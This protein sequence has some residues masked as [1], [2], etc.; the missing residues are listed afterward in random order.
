MI[1]IKDLLN[2]TDNV[3]QQTY[4]EENGIPQ[5][6][7][8][9]A[10][11]FVEK[12][13]KPILEL[14]NESVKAVKKIV[15]GSQTYVP[16]DGTI[17]LPSEEASV[18]IVAL[19]STTSYVETGGK[20]A[21]HVRI[22]STEGGADTGSI[23]EVE[24]Q[25]FAN[26]NY[27]TILTLSLPSMPM[28][29]TAFEEIDITDVI[30]DGSSQIR[31]VAKDETT[32]AV[33]R[34]IFQSVVKAT[35]GVT[36]VFAW[37]RAITDLDDG[38]PV[39]YAISGT[40]VQKTMHL[41]IYSND[42]KQYRDFEYIIGTSTYT[43]ANPWTPTVNPNDALTDIVKI[44]SHGV[45]TIEAWVTCTSDDNTYS[46]DHVRNQVM[47]VADPSSRNAYLM[48]QQ[49]NTEVNNYVQEDPLFQFAVYNPLNPEEG[50]KVSFLITD[51]NQEQSYMNTESMAKNGTK[52]SVPGTIEI[53]GASL[54][55]SSYAYFRAKDADGFN[56]LNGTDSIIITVDNNY[57]FS[58]VSGADLYINPSNR[59][60]GEANPAQILNAAKKNN[61]VGATFEGFSFDNNDGWIQAAD[62]RRVLRILAGQHV[63]IDYDPFAEF[64]TNYAANVTIELDVKI[65]N[66]TNETD[67]II[68]IANFVLASGK[69]TGAR[70]Y[71]IEGLVMTSSKTTE[72]E[73][74]FGFRE[75]VRTHI[76]IN[77]CSAIYADPDSRNTVP[78]VR[79]FVNANPYREFMFALKQNE[80]GRDPY[81]I[82]IG[83]SGADIDIYSIKVYRKALSSQN[84]MQNYKSSLPTSAQ[85]LTFAD[86]NDIIG[87]DGTIS[88][89]LAREKY[90]CIVHHGVPTSI[91][92]PDATTCWLHIDHIVNGVYDKD[93]SGDICRETASLPVKGQGSTAKHYCDW[94]Q[95]YD[96]KK[97]KGKITVDGAEVID[98]WI[99]GNG[100]YKGAYY[101][102]NTKDAK[103]NKLVGKIN[104][105]SSMQSHKMGATNAYNDLYHAVMG[106]S[107][108]TIMAEDSKARCTC[109]ED[110][111]FFFV[112]ETETSTPRFEGI[113]TFGSGK[114]DKKT[115]GYD[116]EVY[117]DFAMFEGSDNDQPVT[118]FERPWNDDVTYNPAEEYYEYNGKGNIDF[119]AGAVYEDEDE[120]EIPTGIA[121]DV[122]KNFINFG[123]LHCTDLQ[124]WTNNGGTATSLINAAD[125]ADIHS[126]Y[127]ITSPDDIAEIGDLFSWSPL[128]AAW[129]RA[130]INREN[131]NIFDENPSVEFSADYAATN[132]SLIESIITRF[133]AS[134]KNY[135]NVRSKLFHSC[136][137]ENLLAGSDNCAKNT[138]YV[139]DP[140]KH[141]INFHADDL[142]TIFKTD[143]VGWQTK[144]YYVDRVHHIDD[145]GVE[146]YSG[147][148][149][150]FFNTFDRAYENEKQQMMNDI[151]TAMA[152]IGGSVNGFM[153]KYFFGIQRAIPCIAY[154]EQARIRYEKRQIQVNENIITLD[155][156]DPITQQLGSQLE[157]EL[158]Y[159]DRRLVYFMSYAAYGSF[160]VGGGSGVSGSFG[161]RGF[162]KRNGG[163]ARI[164]FTVRPHQY[165]YP[166]AAFG[167]TLINPH[168][169]LSPRDTYEILIE[170][171]CSSDTTCS[172]FGIDF[173]REI[174]NIG[175]ISVNPAYNITIGGKR[176]TKIEAVPLSGDGEFRPAAINIT[177]RLVESV[178]INCADVGSSINMSALTRLKSIDLRK[179]SINTC[180]IPETQ[181]LEEIRFGEKMSGVRIAGVPNLSALTLEGYAYLQ[182]VY[183]GS[184]NDKLDSLVFAQSIYNAKPTG[185]RTVQ[186]LGV[187]W[188]NGGVN[189]P[190]PGMVMWFVDNNG[191]FTGEIN[192]ASASGTYGF[193]DKRKLA[194]KF[195]DIDSPENDLYL[196]YRRVSVSDIGIY[197]DKY[198]HEEICDG[199]VGNYY[200]RGLYVQPLNINAN[201]VRIIGNRLAIDW[202][203]SSNPHA[204]IN[205]ESGVVHIT[206]FSDQYVNYV[207]S[208]NLTLING[209]SVSVDRVIG[210]YRRIPRL[211]D[212][213][214]MDGTFDDIYDNT[215][216][217][218][219]IVFARLW[220]EFNPDEVTRNNPVLKYEKV[221]ND[222]VIDPKAKFMKLLIVSK[223]YMRQMSDTATP[224]TTSMSWG[225]YNDTTGGANGFTAAEMQEVLNLINERTGKSYT[226]MFDVADITQFTGH[227]L[228]TNYAY[229][230]YIQALMTTG[231]D[232]EYGGYKKQYTPGVAAVN[233]AIGDWNGREHTEAVVRWADT[234][235]QT[236]VNEP[237]KADGGGGL[238]IAM[239]PPRNLQELADYMYDVLYKQAGGGTKAKY[240]QFAYPAAYACHLYQPTVNRGEVDEQLKQGRW[241]LPSAGE[242]I[243]LYHHYNI[244]RN[245]PMTTTNTATNSNTPNKDYADYDKEQG[246]EG[247]DAWNPIF[248]KMYERI[249]EAGG[250]QGIF[251]NLS[252][253]GHWSSSESNALLA[254]YVYF[255]SSYV[256]SNGKY[257]SFSVRPV[258]AYI[259]SL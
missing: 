118:N 80:W 135:Y 101:Y 158:Q 226:S 132:E 99:D 247:V 11:E 205:A 104:Y 208:A 139:V 103:S 39:A 178:Q 116:D 188:G 46:S 200:Y 31:I 254:W 53:E 108:D 211:G 84:V 121:V 193:D 248:A 94:N 237:K 37:E 56:M 150:M 154:L 60:N 67:P 145:D 159:M 179:S 19:E 9:P 182:D 164:A 21:L 109:K 48:L 40:Q 245:N 54:G 197:G 113:M 42:G 25:R 91:Q 32:G 234:I 243:R 220:Y 166:T 209:S 155:T 186:F 214:Y 225:L 227:G 240:Y 17:V 73:Q 41:R 236:W 136:F 137:V 50:T 198:I 148:H 163:G 239:D 13:V 190:A 6:E 258:A 221:N 184:G 252:A 251:A 100:K 10:S 250:N 187:N 5:E 199:T 140:V 249:A 229:A 255:N 174:G 171:S 51:Y 96:A 16:E 69:F 68:D 88:Y 185:L 204:T 168:V 111:F 257:N 161:F 124:P 71:P 47:V 3:E 157:S 123:Y 246:F 122:M 180:D 87:A 144:P 117:P 176:L 191:R 228:P 170:K 82:E 175:D 173:Y 189:L 126:Q 102:L 119:D 61:P 196:R 66:V 33:G 76:A 147:T 134:G 29:S 85:K 1:D 217:L 70:I 183:V 133:K 7:T 93:T 30:P 114:M 201:D 77:I 44:M 165:L 143:N 256:N 26:G 162:P 62:G 35:L 81:S 72:G 210:F 230:D 106:D 24:V 156:V 233:T 57:D 79:V 238:G 36:P 242:L 110:M 181:T 95:Q 105:A 152:S 195:G 127:W 55:V 177:A 52:Y 129:V 142:D 259:F 218:A 23:M 169:R 78:L 219:G 45:H 15:R 92:H 253:S 20:V 86:A 151:L 125:S 89:E 65:S 206:S 222:Y 64:Q 149:N 63:H 115:W 194:E 38:I 2:K 58:P 130:G 244:S 167:Q 8:L 203:L 4:V 28:T 120:N 241:Y 231:E 223:E 212:F 12:I 215:K 207:V 14:Q 146:C 213:C 27:T 97:A 83:Q 224:V 235:I 216:D 90:S 141:I 128:D 131:R 172:L 138:Y 75:D 107:L 98:G 74:N 34:L 192:S 43:L 49:L 59:N 153:E 202:A 18:S 22:V 160:S 232:S 112:Q